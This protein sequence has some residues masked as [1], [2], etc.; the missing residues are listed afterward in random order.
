MCHANNNHQKKKHFTF[1]DITLQSSYIIWCVPLQLMVLL[2][3]TS[4]VVVTSWQNNTRQ[5]S[6]AW[7]DVRARLHNHCCLGY[8]ACKSFQFCVVFYCRLWTVWLYRIFPHYLANV[9]QFSEKKLLDIK[10]V[11]WFSVWLLSETYI[12]VRRIHWEGI[13]VHRSL[14]KVPLSMSDFNETWI[15]SLHFWIILIYQI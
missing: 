14:C 9:A 4:C 10:W 3:S 2:V 7:C 15:L 1:T 8:P 11:F 13:N 5:A 6:S 12:T